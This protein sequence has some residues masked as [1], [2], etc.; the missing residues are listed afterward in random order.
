M[1]LKYLRLNDIP[2]IE[3]IYMVSISSVSLVIF[4]VLIWCII[5]WR[6]YFAR[7]NFVLVAVCVWFTLYFILQKGIWGALTPGA[8]PR[9]AM[10]IYPFLVFLGALAFTRYNNSEMNREPQLE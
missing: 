8:G 5:N 7:E 6:T 9:Y 10:S 4:L 2:V 3:L 1:P